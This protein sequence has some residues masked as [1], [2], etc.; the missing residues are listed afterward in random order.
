MS[1][2]HLK[3]CYPQGNDSGQSGNLSK[4]QQRRADRRGRG[5]GRGSGSGSD[6]GRGFRGRGQRQGGYK[7]LH[8][9]FAAGHSHWWPPTICSAALFSLRV[10]SCAPGGPLMKAARS[11]KPLLCVGAAMPLYRATL[12]SVASVLLQ[13]MQT[14]RHALTAFPLGPLRASLASSAN[15]RTGQAPAS[16]ARLLPMCLL[17]SLKAQQAMLLPPGNQGGVAAANPAAAGAA[18]AA[19]TQTVSCA[20][21]CFESVAVP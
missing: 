6:R 5:G 16:R 7:Q 10:C 18:A 20:C 8:H 11:S 21:N 9:Q 12:P 4:N 14:P 1:G 13:A 15:F 3:R 2:H 19:A 17:H